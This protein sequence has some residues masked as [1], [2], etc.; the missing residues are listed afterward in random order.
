MVSSGV[1]DQVEGSVLMFKQFG[2][3]ISLRRPPPVYPL[4]SIAIIRSEFT[5][6]PWNERHPVVLNQNQGI[7]CPDS[8]LA[9]LSAK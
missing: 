7:F 6:G 4:E 5:G 9:E 1:A 3:H 2:T 8:N